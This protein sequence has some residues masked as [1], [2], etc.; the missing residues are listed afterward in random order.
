MI[1]SIGLNLT[2]LLSKIYIKKFY[3]MKQRIMQVNKK[4]K[5]KRLG[6]IYDQRL[7]IQFFFKMMLLI[8]PIINCIKRDD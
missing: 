2:Q 7:L 6:L 5:L 8:Y 3:N 4:F 1:M